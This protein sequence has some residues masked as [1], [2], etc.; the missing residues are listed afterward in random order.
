MR[1]VCLWLLLLCVMGG[2]GCESRELPRERMEMLT[3]KKE[4]PTGV[5]YH[6]DASEG[7]RSYFSQAMAEDLYGAHG[8]ETMQKH[9]ESFCIFLSLRAEPYEIAVFRAY[10]GTSANRLLQLCLARR[11]ELAVQLR[12]TSYADRP[13]RAQIYRDGCLVIMLLTD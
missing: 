4:L 5:Y 6:S 7:S 13:S 9:A 2:V 12:H 3:Q 8:W 1:R 11:E 10:S